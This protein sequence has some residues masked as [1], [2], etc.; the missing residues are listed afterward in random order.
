MRLATLAFAALLLGLTACGPQGPQSKQDT[1][2]ALTGS[3]KA[4]ETAADIYVRLPLCPQP[5]PCR[6]AGVAAKIGEADKQADGLLAKYRAGTATA[7][8]VTA[9]IAGIVSLIPVTK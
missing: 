7:V 6:T 5:T 9:A 1:V 8:D 4:A 3:L 2:D